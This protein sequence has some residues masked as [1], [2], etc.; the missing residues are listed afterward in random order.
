MEEVPSFLLAAIVTWHA[1]ISKPPFVSY[2][3]FVCACDNYYERGKKKRL[4]HH[5]LPVNFSEI[6][7][8]ECT[9]SPIVYQPFSLPKNN[10]NDNNNNNSTKIRVF[11]VCLFVSP[12][13]LFCCCC[14]FWVYWLEA[15]VNNYVVKIC[16][17]RHASCNQK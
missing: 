9:H 13:C 1:M 8:N 11:L 16:K 17:L 10:N 4:Q 6:K 14:C 3:D 2:P 15:R 5:T 12:L 7:I